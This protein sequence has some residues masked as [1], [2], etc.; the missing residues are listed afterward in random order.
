MS[1]DLE[2][3]KRRLVLCHKPGGRCVYDKTAKAEFVEFCLRPGVS[4]SRLAREVGINANQVSKWI[5]DH[6]QQRKRAAVVTSPPLSPFVAVPVLRTPVGRV[7]GEA[8]STR[9]I[10]LQA[11]LPNGVTI[12]LRGVGSRQIEDVIQTLGR[13]A[14]SASTTT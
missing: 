14:C 4:V 10:S 3:L 7:V 8:S 6:G 12:E 2:D 13:L 9:E 11:R 1:C 5:R